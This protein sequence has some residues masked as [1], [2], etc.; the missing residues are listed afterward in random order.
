MNILIVG[1]QEDIKPVLKC[2]KTANPTILLWENSDTINLLT[3]SY[4]N[5][6]DCIVVAINHKEFANQLVLLLTEL[7]GGDNRNILNYYYMF[8]AFVP[9]MVVDRVMCNNLYPDYKGMILGISHAETGLLPQCF[10]VPF[11]NLAV[12]SQDIYYN[13]KVLEYCVRTYPDKI[14]NLKYIIL[15]MFDYTYFNY[16]VSLSKTAIKYYDWGGYPLD[17]HNFEQNKNFNYHF[18]SIQQALFDKKYAGITEHHLDL[19]DTIFENVHELDEYK[20]FT[21]PR[22]VYYRNHIV[23]EEQVETFNANTNIVS[24]VFDKTIEENKI[25]F[26]MLMQ[27]IYALNPNMKVLLLIMPRYKGI[28]DKMKIPYSP[29][30]ERFYEIIEDAN[31]KYPFVFLDYK[32]HP[33]S[34]NK[35]LYQDVSHLNYFGAV[36]F[37]RMINQYL[38]KDDK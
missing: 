8:H 21:N 11:C 35:L 36:N 31:K 14:R 9:D 32:E 6:F 4:L 27:L 24:K 19:W 23:T 18:S 15:D 25:Y 28:H 16:D 30:K 26:D 13:M 22:E 3:T 37:T 2:L 29:W 10:D 20:E 38:L 34:A 33:I 7:L 1:I 5:Q 17:E 12:S